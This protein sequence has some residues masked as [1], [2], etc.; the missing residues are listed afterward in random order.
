[1]LFDS[2]TAKPDTPLNEFLV[3]IPVTHASDWWVCN[4]GVSK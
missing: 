3:L 4:N 1:M 2:S